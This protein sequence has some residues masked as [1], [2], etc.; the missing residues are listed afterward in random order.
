MDKIINPVVG[1]ISQ[2]CSQALQNMSTARIKP[3]FGLVA[4]GYSSGMHENRIVHKRIQCPDR[5]KSRRHALQVRIEGGYVRICVFI[6]WGV[7][8]VTIFHGWRC[9]H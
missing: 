9:E 6:A 5:K 8:P 7:G 4:A 3:Q 1:H 2:L